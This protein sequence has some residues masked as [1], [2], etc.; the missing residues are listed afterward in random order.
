MDLR[1]GQHEPRFPRE[2]GLEEVLHG[3]PE[4]QG[5]RVRGVVR[6]RVAD[7]TISVE[8]L[9]DCHRPH[10]GEP[11]AVREG[12]EQRRVQRDGRA[13]LLLVRVHGGDPPLRREAR[14][15][16]RRLRLVP[17]M[18]RVLDVLRSELCVVLREDRHDPP[19]WGRDELLDLPLAVPD[20]GEGGGLHP[21]DGQDVP[22][23]AAARHREE[24]R[25]DRTPGEVDRLPCR[26]GGRQVLVEGPQ[27]VERLLDLAAGEG[28]EPCTGN[29]GSR[30]QLVG[31][32]DRL[33]ADQLSLAVEVGRNDDFIGLS[34]GDAKGVHGRRIRDRGHRFRVNEVVE[35]RVL[36][37]VQLRGIVEVHEVAAEGKR[38]PKGPREG[39]RELAHAVRPKSFRL[40]P[41]QDRCQAECGAELLSDE[42]SV[43][44]V[45]RCAMLLLNTMSTQRRRN[46]HS[47]G[48]Q[49]PAGSFLIGLRA[50]EEAPTPIRSHI[51][52]KPSRS[53]SKS[54]KHQ[55]PGEGVIMEDEICENKHRERHDHP[56][57]CG[58]EHEP[59][60]IDPFRE[61]HPLEHGFRHSVRLDE[62]ADGARNLEI[63]RQQG[64]ASPPFLC[65]NFQKPGFRPPNLA[66]V[67]PTFTNH[68]E[69]S[70]PTDSPCQ[71][72]G[73]ERE[74]EPNR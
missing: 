30:G 65:E 13:V 28:G 38:P 68:D 16:P 74:V 46:S 20:K 17:M 3:P 53:P 44:P 34:R 54:G 2:I 42:E 9:R 66:K 40:P 5:H 19:P 23:M 55:E 73:E 57:G 41:G 60:G 37:V 71:Q 14:E 50:G 36:P 15:G 58:D 31:D 39:K 25:E 27:V 67:F 18:E 72:F 24:P 4:A 62:D 59:A 7:Q 8:G 6:A 45:N 48:Q 47:R 52:A 56:A 61:A 63:F 22:P 35:V 29:P 12:E 70:G 10:R 21:P 1:Q 32:T 49:G 43:H 33:E 11:R 26:G 64:R 69:P 51:D